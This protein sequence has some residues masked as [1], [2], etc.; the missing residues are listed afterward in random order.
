VAPR[1]LVDPGAVRHRIAEG[2]MNLRREVEELERVCLAEAL[3]AAGGNASRA[4]TL[5]GEVGR[6]TSSD[7]GGTVRGMVKRLGL[8]S[9][10]RRRR[11]KP[12]GLS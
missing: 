9:L 6:G 5:L 3:A 1:G 12:R 4:A 7:P 10:R 8:S 2:T 11:R